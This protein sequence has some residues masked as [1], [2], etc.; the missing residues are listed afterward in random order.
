PD[1]IQSDSAGPVTLFQTLPSADSSC[2]H[3]DEL[4]LRCVL[5]HAAT[6]AESLRRPPS[7]DANTSQISAES[8][9]TLPAR[10]GNPAAAHSF[11]ALSR[12]A[13]TPSS[14]VE[15]CFCA[16]SGH[17]S[18]IRS[19]RPLPTYANNWGC[20]DVSPGSRKLLSPTPTSRNR[21]CAL[22]PTR[23]RS[24][25]TMSVSSSQ[26]EGGLSV[27]WLRVRILKSLVFSFSTTV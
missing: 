22:S 23:S 20:A 21:C 17:S 12:T 1:A 2:R 26:E 25:N 11:S 8:P 3:L 18:P 5:L 9:P 4:S 7:P 27:V 14:L 10:Q 16:S 19:D 13:P 24:D 15:I 6:S